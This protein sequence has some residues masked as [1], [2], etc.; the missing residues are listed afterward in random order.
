MAADTPELEP[1]EIQAGTTVKWTRDYPDFP[2]ADWTL[3]YA[4]RSRT[5]APID[6]TAT[7]ED[8]DHTVNEAYSTTANWTPGIYLMV[9]YMTSDDERHE[10][11]SG[12]ITIAAYTAGEQAYDS[13]TWLDR[14]IDGLET[15]IT[16]RAARYQSH[17]SEL[18]RSVTCDS[19]TEMLATRDTLK[20]ERA[21]ERRKGQMTSV[22]VRY[23]APR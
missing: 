22:L 2:A 21:K 15:A 17:Y 13:R 23:R 12:N 18:G 10:V 19:L 8:G 3:T 14:T 1:T 4:L 5:E 20:A 16:T 6:I 9:G 11:Y 7:N